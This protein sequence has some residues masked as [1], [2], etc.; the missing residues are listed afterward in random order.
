VR[1]AGAA[2]VRI[3]HLSDLHASEDVPLDMIEHAFEVGLTT[4]PH[5]ICLTGDYKT[6]K[7]TFD[8]SRYTR[9]F[10]RLASAAPVFA[11]LGNHDGGSWDVRAGGHPDHTLIESV[12]RDGGVHLLHNAWARIGSLQLVGVG[13]W[14]SGEARPKEAFQGIES[15]PRVVLSHNPD[16][17][18][19]LA[20][21]QW[22][23]M[24]CGHTH[25]GQVVIPMV[26][27]SYAP[28]QDLEYVA[29]LKPWKDRQIFVTR[30]VGNLHGIRFRCRPE[31]SVLEILESA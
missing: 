8:A 20:P 12:L 9:A 16:S 28:V 11:V 21:F 23:L 31:V 4:K 7:S 22:D 19:E 25:G 15:G 18:Q 27:P 17:K 24:L 1:I 30:G 3:L 26:G 2:A 10:R 6:A 5:L 14:W 29:G 13:D